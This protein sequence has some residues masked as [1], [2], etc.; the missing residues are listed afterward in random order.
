MAAL[1][2]WS[3]CVCIFI[4]IMEKAKL[5]ISGLEKTT[6]TIQS[7]QADS[8]LQDQGFTLATLGIA[9]ELLPAYVR[10]HTW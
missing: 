9:E 7:K 4:R 6:E 10:M 1:S 3:V 8:V 2:V 5:V